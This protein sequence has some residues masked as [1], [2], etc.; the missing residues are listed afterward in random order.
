MWGCYKHFVGS[1]CKGWNLKNG[2][3]RTDHYK[4]KHPRMRLGLAGIPLT[5]G[6]REMLLTGDVRAGTESLDSVVTVG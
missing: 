2:L 3:P 6:S 5:P 4:E 1:A